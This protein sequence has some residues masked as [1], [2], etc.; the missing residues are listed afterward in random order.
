[1]V[2]LARQDSWVHQDHPDS[3]EE[4][5]LLELKEPQVLQAFQVDPAHLAFRDIQVM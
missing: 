5:V 2:R 1:L 3:Q 4:L